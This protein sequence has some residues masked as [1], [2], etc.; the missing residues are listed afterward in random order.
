MDLKMNDVVSW[1]EKSGL[2]A[3][4]G[5]VKGF[6]STPMALLGRGVIIEIK[7]PVLL[8]KLEGVDYH[9]T[10]VVIFESGL[11]KVGA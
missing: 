7:D 9:F 4:S 6:S 2:P 5:K 3:G 10:N 11:T 1:E 8:R